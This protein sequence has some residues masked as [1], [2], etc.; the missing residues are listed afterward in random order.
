M[1]A[2]YV[3]IYLFHFTEQSHWQNNLKNWDLSF[4]HILFKTIA[5][6]I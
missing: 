6:S 5:K 1:L 3:G 4:V 2:A